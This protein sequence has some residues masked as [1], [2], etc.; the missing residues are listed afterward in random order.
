MLKKKKIAVIGDT[1]G[2]GTA[3]SKVAQDL[4]QKAGVTPV[5]VVLVDPNKTDL[6]DE[7]NK[8]KAARCRSHHAVVGRDR[9]ARTPVQHARR[10][11]LGTCRS[12][13]IPR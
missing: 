12:S 6:T 10:H 4:L 5:Y 1:S 7:L 2:Y 9:P 8:A 11:G 13:A 3:A